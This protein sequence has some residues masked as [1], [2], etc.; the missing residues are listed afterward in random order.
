MAAPR[1]GPRRA[2]AALFTSAQRRPAAMETKAV[3]QMETFDFHQHL[4]FTS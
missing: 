2:E 4:H 1:S 3:E